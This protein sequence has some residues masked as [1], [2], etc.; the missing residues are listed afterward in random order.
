MLKCLGFMKSCTHWLSGGTVEHI[1][2]LKN[3]DDSGEFVPM[4]YMKL[5]FCENLVSWKGLLS[6]MKC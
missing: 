3:T 2:L 6:I 1:S 4:L 5:R